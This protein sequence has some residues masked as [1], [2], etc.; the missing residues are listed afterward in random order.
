MRTLETLIRLAT[1]HAKMRLSKTVDVNDI[2]I[3][4]KL[5]NNTI[6]Q[7]SEG[8]FV[9]DEDEYEEDNDEVHVDQINTNT[10]SKRAK[11]RVIKQ[12][13]SP[14]RQIKQ[15]DKT[16]AKSTHKRRTTTQHDD[17]DKRPSKKMKVDDNAVV[18]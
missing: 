18:S 1:A 8:G 15:E 13:N 12:E 7:E 4:A 2:E 17:Q 3:G 14:G 9:K 11:D 6:F 10:R 5:L 16:P